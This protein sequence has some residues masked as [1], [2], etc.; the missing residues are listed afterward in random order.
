M[1]VDP[2]MVEPLAERTRDLYAD[3]EQRLFGIIARQLDKGL[4]APGWAER[5][6]AAVQ[7]LRRAA[8]AV[9]DD[10][11][12]A[13]TLDVFDA[14]A[15][16]H[17][18]GHRAAVAELGL[19]GPEK[20]A[21]VD[22]ITPQAQA[23]DRIAAETVDVVTSV[24][25]SILRT[26]VDRYRA[27]VSEVAAEPLLGTATRRQATQRAMAKWAGEG[28]GSFTD[29]S[30]RRWQLTSY[31]EMAVR[32]G[33][34]RAAV[35]SH[36]HTLRAADVQLVIVSDSPRECDLCRPYERQ[37]LS[38]DG[39]S[40]RHTV[41]V[42]HATRDGEY[43][44]V[45]VM[46]SL[47][48][49]R[50]AGLQHPNCRH[51]VSAYTPGLT[52][53]GNATSDPDGYKAGQ[54]QRD[55]ERT[56]RKWKR[57]ETAALTPEAKRRARRYVR[58]WQATMREHLDAHPDLRRLRQREQIGAGNAPT[59]RRNASDEAQ[60]A[61]RIRSGDTETPAELSEQQLA[62]AVRSGMLDAR[63]LG[64]IEQETDR[65][66]LAALVDRATERGAL[67]D[68]LTGF[69]DE[70]L[71]TL[72]QALADDRATLRI[73][74]ELDRRDIDSRL[75]GA[76]PDLIGLSDEDLAA[77]ARNADPGT[78]DAI[79][80]EANRRDMI[81]DL[82]PGGTL[83]EDL[84]E[85]GDDVLAWA[86]RYADEAE[87][88]RIAA[89]IDRR[90][91]PGPLPEVSTAADGAEA[92]LDDQAALA[93]H[94]EPMPDPDGW[95]W[96]ADDAAWAAIRGD[97]TDD[98]ADTERGEEREQRFTRR[99]ARALYDEHV[100]RQYLDAEDDCRGY[101]L[102]PKARAAGID[103][104]SLFSG[105]AHVAFAHASEELVRWWMEH[106]RMTQAEFIAK[107][108]GTSSREATRAQEA[109]HAAVSRWKGGGSR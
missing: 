68:D 103:P 100:T 89:E 93:E 69:S 4:E 95:G 30:G 82:F 34:G 67:A 61:A 83:A 28:I 54:R 45:E 13:V 23:V 75:P 79:A 31:A 62:A 46:D 17:N 32:T 11:A 81:R 84:A 101:L 9:V 7:T 74:A 2:S 36:M 66:D 106:G 48:G 41:Q 44:D 3:A 97:D 65:R 1:P 24:H 98:E 21:M 40:G 19:L 96:L 47:D 51:S 105:P 10:L 76:R 60:A 18:R 29:R 16:A 80:E 72:M 78:L 73:A 26:T 86:T 5:K 59:P 53:V 87:A 39:T 20:R 85:H 6:L 42:E 57:E 55:I 92:F 22:E 49:A 15:D 43:V 71:G 37:V 102:N 35:E 99:Q 52:R 63:A 14:V 33:V 94:M 107:A 50:R 108:T 88:V 70:Q 109:F 25:R 58:K 77:R 64:R 91:E 56:I 27:V 90:Y 8:Q 104:V 38:L 12:E